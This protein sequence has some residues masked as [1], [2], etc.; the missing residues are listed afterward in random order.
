[1]IVSPR[2]VNDLTDFIKSFYGIQT[3]TE[4]WD[5]TLSIKRK[6]KQFVV[7]GNCRRVV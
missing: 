6:K 4:L 3:L 5:V 2:G 1:M 7:L